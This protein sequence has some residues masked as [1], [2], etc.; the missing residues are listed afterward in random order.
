MRG[1][2]VRLYSFD[3]KLNGWINID[4]SKMLSSGTFASARMASIRILAQ[5]PA[6]TSTTISGMTSVQWSGNTGVTFPAYPIRYFQPTAVPK[7]FNFRNPSPTML[8]NVL[9]SSKMAISGTLFVQFSSVT[10]LSTPLPVLFSEP[11]LT[12]LLGEG[13]EI[14]MASTNPS[15][16]ASGHSDILDPNSAQEVSGTDLVDLFDGFSLE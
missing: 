8:S 7:S 3:L 9:I 12:P 1:S 15:S 14:G 2:V 10:F 16:F 13:R 11:S 5:T 6:Q 4:T